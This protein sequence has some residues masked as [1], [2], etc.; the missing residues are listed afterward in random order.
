MRRINRKILTNFFKELSQAEPDS[1]IKDF[2]FGP[3]QEWDSKFEESQ[4]KIE[5]EI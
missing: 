3:S 4:L 1:R 2:N 5:S